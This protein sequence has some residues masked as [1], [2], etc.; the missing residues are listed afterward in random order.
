MIALSLIPRRTPCTVPP[1]LRRLR[2]AWAW[3]RRTSPAADRIGARCHG[4]TEVMAIIPGKPT[5]HTLSA[6]TDTGDG[7]AIQIHENTLVI[8]HFGST[9]DQITIPLPTH[10]HAT[11]PRPHA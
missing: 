3:A 4:L 8:L 11:L 6:T 7:V 2:D 1:E 9:P 10:L 5:A